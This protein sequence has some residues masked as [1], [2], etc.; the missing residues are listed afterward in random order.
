MGNPYR[1]AKWISTYYKL[2]LWDLRLR[3]G[4]YVLDAVSYTAFA[5]AQ[6]GSCH[7]GKRTRWLMDIKPRM[8][9]PAEVKPLVWIVGRLGLNLLQRACAF[10][11]K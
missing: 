8:T 7:P 1:Q 6:A 4:I 2:Q 10:E 9:S 5:V 3:A 11:R